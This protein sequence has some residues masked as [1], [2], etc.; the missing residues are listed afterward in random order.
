M[1]GQVTGFPYWEMAFDQT[2]Q[3]TSPATFD[4]LVA[5]VPQQALTDLFLMSHGWNNTPQAA[6]DLYARYFGQIRALIDAGQGAKAASIGVVGII[7]PSMRWADE[8]PVAQAGGAM[9]IRTHPPDAALV[10]DLKAVYTEPAQQQALDT[11]AQLLT[12]RPRDPQA[13][14]Q[15]QQSMRALVATPDAAAAPED[16]G[17]HLLFDLDAEQ[18]FKDFSRL[19]PPRPIGGAAGVGDV[20]GSLWDGAK[21]ALRATTYWEMKRRAGVVGQR[22]V[23]PLMMRLSSAQPNLRMHLIG[24]SFG[25]RVAAFS[26]SGLPDTA[27][28]TTS[29]VRSVFLL[30]GAFSHFSFASA[31]PF[32]HSRSGALANMLTRVNGPFLVSHTLKDTAVGTFYPM[33]SMLAH[34]DASATDDLLFRWGAMGHDGAQA[35]DAAEAPI[36]RVGT[37]YPFVSG[38]ALNLDGN[39]LIVNG[40]PPDGAHGDIFHPEIAW[41][42]L[43]AAGLNA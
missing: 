10:T 26:L 13:L 15:F 21:E 36:G 28:S 38:G 40:S 27:T 14:V 11:L 41:A 6:R 3:L 24:H 25:A 18:V 20:F 19:A 12:T 43:A 4:Q 42:S 8:T 5:E 35:V 1:P 39:A 2:G 9:S 31:L 7:W 30:Q 17:D 16:N 29:P 37:A 32:D 33:A 23:G 34:D 22:G